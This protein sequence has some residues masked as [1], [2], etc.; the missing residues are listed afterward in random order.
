MHWRHRKVLFAASIALALLLSLVA[1]PPVLAAFK[2]AWI[3]LV[4]LFWVIETTDPVELGWVFCIGLLADLFNGSLLG[5][6][7]LRLTVLVFIAM[8]FRARLRFFPM[9]QQT[10]AVLALLLND[11]MLLLMVRAFA[12]EA[13]PPLAWWYA[14]FAGALLWPFVFLLLDDLRTRMRVRE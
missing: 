14:P 6:H 13:L 2:P 5:E 8:R 7:A 1:L 4:L 11:R 10:L 12:G 9:W 3:A